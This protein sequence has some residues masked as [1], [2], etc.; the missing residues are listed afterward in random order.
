MPRVAALLLATALLAGHPP[1]SAAGF[2]RAVVYQ[3]R[4]LRDWLAD[5]RAKD[6]SVVLRASR[7]LRLVGPEA[8]DAAPALLMALRHDD[9][10][11]RFRLARALAQ[12]GP[13]QVPLLTAALSF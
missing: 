9:L 4:T 11:V 5:L 1:A 2:D 6:E 3:A 7:V 13:R 10:T 8:S 12:T